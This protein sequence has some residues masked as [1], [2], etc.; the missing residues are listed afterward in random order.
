MQL[1]RKKGNIMSLILTA[2]IIFLLQNSYVFQRLD[3][4]YNN[5]ISTYQL[6]S[7]YQRNIIH[8]DLSYNILIYLHQY[9]DP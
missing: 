1:S 7:A 4:K 2:Y 3:L 8:L 6:N 9:P 5:L